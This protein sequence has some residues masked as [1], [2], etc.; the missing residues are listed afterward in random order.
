[1]RSDL[2][3]KH[4]A[5]YTTNVKHVMQQYL[6]TKNGMK[7]VDLVVGEMDKSDSGSLLDHEGGEQEEALRLNIFD[8]YESFCLPDST[9]IDREGLK[10]LFA[11]LRLDMTKKHFEAYMRKLKI[12]DVE[13]VSDFDTFFAVL[14][15]EL[16][17]SRSAQSMFQLFTP[18]EEEKQ[19]R[20]RATL[21]YKV[22]TR[23]QENQAKI[24]IQDQT[25]H[26]FELEAREEYRRVHPCALICLECEEAFLDAQEL[27]KHT[28]DTALHVKLLQAKMAIQERFQVVQ[29]VFQGN[30][31]R[32]LRA[33]RLIFS[34]DLCSLQSRID[35]AQLDPYRPRIADVGARRYKQQVAGGMV[36]GHD[37]KAGVRSHFRQSGLLRQ[38]HQPLRN[39]ANSN[40]LYQVQHPHLQEILHHLQRCKDDFIDTVSTCDNP[41]N[42]VPKKKKRKEEGDEG[43][44][45]QLEN[46]EFQLTDRSRDSEQGAQEDKVFDVATNSHGMCALVRFQWNMAADS[47]VSLIAEFNGW[48]PEAMR[49]SASTNLFTIMKQLSP[50]RYKYRFITDG[51]ERVDEVASQVPD[52]TGPGGV[53]NEILITNTP[54]YHIHHHHH[55][56]RS[57][58][59]L[60]A[61]AHEQQIKKSGL[62]LPPTPKSAKASP[63]RKSG[64]VGF[65][66]AEQDDMSLEE[67]VESVES[68]HSDGEIVHISQSD[69]E[70][71]IRHLQHIDLRNQ[72]LFDDGAW[73]FSSYINK[74]A[75]ILSIDLSY[76]SISD[77]GIQGFSG[78]L[79]LLKAL[80]TIKLNGNGFGMDSCRYLCNSLADSRTLTTL[81]LSGNRIGDDGAEVLC[82]FLT[83]NECMQNLYV[84]VCLIGD[85]GMECFHHMLMAN[86]AL[87]LVSLQDN[88]FTVTG[89]GRFMLALQFNAC[90]Q[91]LNLGANKI[92][93]EAA[94]LV[95]DGLNLNDTL[96]H[97]CLANFDLVRNG[98]SY[99]L[100]GLCASLAQNKTLTSLDLR[101]NSLRDIHAIDIS[102]ALTKNNSV[103]KIDLAGNPISAEWL[104]AD[105]YI[106]THLMESMPSIET[107]LKRN[108][109]HKLQYKNAFD[110]NGRPLYLDSAV[111]G[112]WTFRR[113][114]RKE[115][116][117][118]HEKL[119]IVSEV[120]GE[121]LRI[122]AEHEYLHAMLAEFMVSSREYLDQAPCER[123]LQ[124]VTKAVSR[125]LHDLGR[126]D[127]KLYNT[128]SM[129]VANIPVIKEKSGQ[130]M[131]TIQLKRQMSGKF[132]SAPST[133]MSMNSFHG[134]IMTQMSSS[135]MLMSPPSSPSKSMS[136]SQ[137]RSLA[138]KQSLA[139]SLT[140]QFL[141]P[142]PLPE[143]VVPEVKLEQSNFNMEFF[144]NAHIT[145]VHAVFSLINGG[146]Y[147]ALVIP[148]PALQQAFQMLALPLPVGE[149][150][151]AVDATLVQA[152]NSTGLHKLSDYVLN[153]AQRLCRGSRVQ[154]LRLL[155]DLHFHPP[156]QEA[157]SIILDHLHHVALIE[158]RE[159]YRHQS[160]HVPR[161]VCPLCHKRFTK[162]KHLDKHASKGPNS[163]EHQRH[164]MKEV[165]HHSQL[166]FLQSVKHDL[167]QLFF[168]AYFELR[169]AHLL[170]KM[171]F[172][173]VFD[174][175]GKEGRPFGVV[176]PN[177]TIRVVDAFGD[178]LHVILH[179]EMG[180]VRYQDRL[181]AYMQPAC[182]GQDGFD[183]DTLHIQDVPTYY[184]VNDVLA[185]EVALK[186]RYMPTAEGEVLGYLHR[187][188]VIECLAVIGDWLQVRYEKEEAAWVRWRITTKDSREAK[189]QAEVTAVAAASAKSDKLSETHDSMFGLFAQSMR[190]MSLMRMSSD[191]PQAPPPL[192]PLVPL[193]SSSLNPL[194]D[195][196]Q[197]R[198]PGRPQMHFA[199]PPSSRLGAD[200]H[201]LQRASARTPGDIAE[202]GDDFFGDDIMTYEINGKMMKVRLRKQPLLTRKKV[203]M[204][205]RARYGTSENG[206]SQDTLLLL[207]DHFQPLFVPPTTQGQL[208]EKVP[209]PFSL[210]QQQLFDHILA[211]SEAE[212]TTRKVDVADE[213]RNNMFFAH[214]RA[215]SPTAQRR[216]N[217][218]AK[219]G[220]YGF[221]DDDEE[222]ADEALHSL[223]RYDF[224]KAILDRQG[225]TH[226]ATKVYP[227][228]PT[229]T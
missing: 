177:R 223:E 140:P 156:V 141:P 196:A 134:P 85:I 171:Y 60:H 147:H 219:D 100:H 173:Q 54:L 22:H 197:S 16:D 200:R 175:I 193:R 71:L 195:S 82:Q 2:E 29:T 150:Q 201:S 162:Q 181:Q 192:R 84:D 49:C 25:V 220:L 63:S 47:K 93:P 112:K 210:D 142:M 163:G 146:G 136:K 209:T 157:K 176:E 190:S 184:R 194:P 42:K 35:V 55:D 120:Q 64:M 153:N 202:E 215:E 111:E 118:N 26:Q 66:E 172:P 198:R 113:Q 131:A 97:I 75:F 226:F 152:F 224:A 137:A 79:H 167:T 88:L 80:H 206:S 20:R 216:V 187:N 130:R 214:A 78:C 104:K 5:Y 158:L 178:Y 6:S 89:V 13:A 166:L 27:K 44:M 46:D 170:P 101:N 19:R 128:Y 185:P 1:M 222:V 10:R 127:S 40:T 53:S 32:H 227:K 17:Q 205:N 119:K 106:S 48:R 145:T 98:N 114:W 110:H 39:K 189:R 74:N 123:Y 159:K 116:Q 8:M 139:R 221:V 76:N 174:N 129:S 133:P 180:W 81:E 77:D 188:Q 96:V 57:A 217:F 30:Q 61:L 41:M 164:R 83:H 103:V 161:F 68:H 218:S 149:V 62:L 37:P 12:F 7:E 23:L 144:L 124:L 154:R 126:F 105:S 117:S 121:A 179:G 109:E 229:S 155:A 207:A 132:E 34:T 65:F 169:A 186:V 14:M 102:H 199:T 148:P 50:G 45:Q 86:R 15:E 94:N 208:R 9:H 151:G 143:E 91:T 160:D 95:G 11:D 213:E 165:I 125:Y 107:L 72:A 52:P 59:P 191:F 73:S 31:G 87:L 204:F 99:G 203:E 108:R 51:V 36:Q 211:T 225:P 33:N 228:K 90:V 18:S 212:L 138:R 24:I 115:S 182:S 21:S 135:S 92:G 3:A 70:G 67:S 69:K 56:K 4:V 58:N 43:E 38:H 28:N 183:W 168:P 122:K